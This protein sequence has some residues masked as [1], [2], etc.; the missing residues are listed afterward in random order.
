MT[1]SLKEGRVCSGSRFEGVESSWPGGHGGAAYSLHVRP[2]AEGGI[3]G[4]Y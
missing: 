4:F 1:K 3:P 2:G